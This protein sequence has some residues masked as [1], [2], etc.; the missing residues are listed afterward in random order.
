[1]ATMNLP[2]DIWREVLNLLPPSTLFKTC[3]LNSALLELSLEFLY[4]E[5]SLSS[6]DKDI[7]ETFKQIVRDQ[8]VATRLRRLRV[9]SS[10]SRRPSPTQIKKFNRRVIYLEDLRRDFSHVPRRRIPH[11]LE[12]HTQKSARR[13]AYP[14]KRT[15]TLGYDDGSNQET[16]CLSNLVDLCVS[17]P[18][19]TMGFDVIQSFLVFLWKT[20][21]IGDGLK[22]L[23]FEASGFDMALLILPTIRAA[24]GFAG[25]TASTTPVEPTLKSPL[26]NIT[27]LTIRLSHSTKT[28]AATT[29]LLHKT[30]RQLLERLPSLSKI[31]IH[32]ALRTD[33]SEVWQLGGPQFANPQLDLSAILQNLPFLPELKAIHYSSPFTDQALTNRKVL[34]DWLRLYEDQLEELV[35]QPISIMTLPQV[36]TDDEVEEEEEEESGSSDGRGSDMHSAVRIPGINPGWRRRRNGPSLP[37]P[38][39][40]YSVWIANHEWGFMTLRFPHLKRLEIE[41]LSP[42]IASVLIPSLRV[43]APSLSSLVIPNRRLAMVELQSLDGFSWPTT[44]TWNWGIDSLN[45]SLRYLTPQIIELLYA[46]LP[47][48]KKL[49]LRYLS[50]GLHNDGPGLNRLK[51]TEFLMDLRGR[52]FPNWQLTHIRIAGIMTRNCA[53]FHPVLEVMRALAS[54]L[55]TGPILDVEKLEPCRCKP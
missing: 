9:V 11:P 20:G 40:E 21:T 44:D 8:Q 47:N 33:Y 15:Y 36:I 51:P 18:D 37:V 27:E 45:I 13:Y 30:F 3:L 7:E 16:I 50:I 49:Q 28:S 54:C 31:S 25:R 24:A 14:T 34:T 12:E 5:V 22:T 42:L 23:T 6:S 35:V 41:P 39:P 46:R 55:N 26:R 1:M 32:S 52:Q 48:L 43:T 53:A 2:G 29:A 19:E 4:E 10:G 38:G 17:F